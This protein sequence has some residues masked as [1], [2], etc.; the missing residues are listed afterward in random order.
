MNAVISRR[1]LQLYESVGYE[2]TV[3]FADQHAL[4]AL[5]FRALM[6]ALADAERHLLARQYLEK[7]RAVSKA[8]AILDGLRATLDFAR[9]GSLA[10]DLDAVYAYCIR[11]LLRGHAENAAEKLQEVRNL[12]GR[13][14]SAWQLIPVQRA[15]AQ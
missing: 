4:V 5:L 10:Q 15:A 13:L 8:Q 9:G 1:T 2:A 3:D 12:L 11:T 7:A 14:E 6:D